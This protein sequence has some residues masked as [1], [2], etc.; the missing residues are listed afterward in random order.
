MRMWSKF[1]T[2]KQNIY[3]KI[4]SCPL[5]YDQEP[6]VIDIVFIHFDL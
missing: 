4:L 1:Q 2:N 3:L 6:P 5:E